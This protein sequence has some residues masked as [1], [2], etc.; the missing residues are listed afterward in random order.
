MIGISQSGQAT[1]VLQTLAAGRAAGAITAS[2]T[3]VGDSP[4]VEASDY[5][6]LCHAGEERAVAATKTY[7][8]SLALVAPAVLAGVLA[9]HTELIESLRAIPELIQT[10]LQLGCDHSRSL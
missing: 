7:T 3:N 1:D 4:I 9:N 2:I 10:T 5:T 6:F 8:T